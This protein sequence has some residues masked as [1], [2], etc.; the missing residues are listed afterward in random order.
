MR[1]IFIPGLGEDELIFSKLI[2]LIDGEKVVL[3]TWQL[4]GDQPR[5]KTNAL[6][7]AKEVMKRYHITKEDVIIGHSMGGL[8]AYCLKMLTG[9]RIV[10]IAS[11]TNH[12]RLIVPISSHTLI[13]MGVKS[14]I[15]FNPLV[16]WLIVKMQYNK[17][18]SKGVLSY[19]FDLLKEGNKHNVINQLK[20]A[21][22]PLKI[23]TSIQPDL[24]IHSRGDKIV[25]P[26]KESYYEVPGDHFSLFTHPEQV[27]AAINQF[28]R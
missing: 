5:G 22:T 8:I 7:F 4:L 26:P 25:R 1:I 6:E 2:P 17:K 15:F 18:P 24:R 10:Q 19:V 3:N 14:R 13:K 9:C 21:L 11:Y 28:F 20:V 12:D 23:N 27:A 16:K